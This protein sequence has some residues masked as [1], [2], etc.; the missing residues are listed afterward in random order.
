MSKND[1][2]TKSVI[3][4]NNVISAIRGLESVMPQGN[5]DFDDFHMMTSMTLGKFESELRRISDDLFKLY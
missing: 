2:I 4:L 3:D 5:D 1:V